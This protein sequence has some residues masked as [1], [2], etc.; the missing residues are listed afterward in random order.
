VLLAV[1][2]IVSGLVLVYAEHGVVQRRDY[3]EFGAVGGLAIL[4]LAI[5]G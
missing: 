5:F 4:L 2:Y 1:F 3:T